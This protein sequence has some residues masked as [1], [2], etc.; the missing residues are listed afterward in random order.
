MAN[1]T[2]SNLLMKSLTCR[3]FMLRSTQWKKI[4]NSKDLHYVYRTEILVAIKFTLFILISI[5]VYD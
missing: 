2:K 4:K 3:T 1:A 5:T